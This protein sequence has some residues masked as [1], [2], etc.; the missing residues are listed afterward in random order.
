M[1]VRPFLLGVLLVEGLCGASSINPADV[2]QQVQIVQNTDQAE[3]TVLYDSHNVYGHAQAAPPQPEALGS[4][5]TAQQTTIF[6]TQNVQAQSTAVASSSVG[7]IPASNANTEA[8][9]VLLGSQA[10]QSNT[11]EALVTSTKKPSS[12]AISSSTAKNSATGAKKGPDTIKNSNNVPA[13]CADQVMFIWMI[14]SQVLTGGHTKDSKLLSAYA[15]SLKGK[16]MSV[17]L[18][19]QI[20]TVLQPDA[21]KEQKEMI[22]L[23]QA[24]SISSTLLQSRLYNNTYG[25]D[26]CFEVNQ[27]LYKGVKSFRGA[28]ELM[29]S[30]LPDLVSSVS[31]SRVDWL[32]TLSGH[33]VN[34]VIGRWYNLQI[35]AGSAFNKL[36]DYGIEANAKKRYVRFVPSSNH[37]SIQ[38]AVKKFAKDHNSKLT[39]D[40]IQDAQIS[41][42]IHDRIEDLTSTGSGNT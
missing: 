34:I 3:N 31:S 18:L 24:N 20:I 27:V 39:V 37:K 9:A 19:R 7:G 13:D 4:A 26:K 41:Y 14:Y 38:D 36:S 25:F 1:L 35:K 21:T 32:K 28:F 15:N 10:L 17:D 6:D 40:D 11:T 8:S 30:E 23:I 16:A 42:E 29:A 33:S 12:S 5:Q 2:N 22:N